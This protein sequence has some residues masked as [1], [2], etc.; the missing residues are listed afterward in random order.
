MLW[1]DLAV[2]LCQSGELS[3]ITDKVKVSKPCLQKKV[4]GKGETWL[5]TCSLY[6]RIYISC[7]CILQLSLCAWSLWV[8]RLR[9]VSWCRLHALNPSCRYAAWI[10]KDMADSA[11]STENYYIQTFTSLTGSVFWLF[12][13]SNEVIR[14]QSNDSTFT[15]E[16]YLMRFKYATADLHC[17]DSTSVWIALFLS[18]TEQWWVWI[19][20]LFSNNNHVL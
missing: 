1:F 17:Y 9:S 3:P 15:G 4:M 5:R 8:T 6:R 10:P 11:T 2:W 13:W 20:K 7:K 19:V 16:M 14:E 18:Q 12:S